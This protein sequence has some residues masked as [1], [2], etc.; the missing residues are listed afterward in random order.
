MCSKEGVW[1]EI[2]KRENVVVVVV[3]ETVGRGW[4]GREGGSYEFLIARL[5]G[6][7]AR[8]G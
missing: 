1:G 6:S 4:E 5:G 8:Q 2:R 3:L 7:R